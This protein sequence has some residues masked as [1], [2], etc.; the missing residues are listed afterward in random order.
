V[1]LRFSG[2]KLEV[3]RGKNTDDP[4][5]DACV[6]VG[7]RLGKTVVTMEEAAGTL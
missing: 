1:G 3:I 7:R 2:E 4:T 6:E 5:M